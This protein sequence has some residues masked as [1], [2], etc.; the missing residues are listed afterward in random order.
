MS[1]RTKEQNDQIR[2][3]RIRQMLEAAAEVYMAKGMAMEMRDIADK[4]ALGYGTAYHYYRN[5]LDLLHDM[6]EE[7]VDLAKAAADDS[8]GSQGEPEM[9]LRRHFHKLTELWTERTSVYILYKLIADNFHHLPDERFALLYD[10]FQAELYQP[11]ART[12]REWAQGHPDPEKLANWTL[13]ALVGSAGVYKHYRR[14]D[15]SAAE[16]V[17]LWFDGLRSTIGSAERQQ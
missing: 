12:M 9:R 16:A 1:P 2:D 15:D 3:K 11:V 14:F 10:R 4:A 6:L 17:D 8:L 13:G 7:A 5:K